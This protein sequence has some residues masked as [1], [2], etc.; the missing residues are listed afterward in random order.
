VVP[1]DVPDVV[2]IVP[3]VGIPS[4][5]AGSSGFELQT[6][7][8]AFDCSLAATDRCAVAEGWGGAWDGGAAERREGVGVVDLGFVAGAVWCALSREGWVGGGEFWRGVLAA[9]IWGKR[10]FRKGGRDEEPVG[11]WKWFLTHDGG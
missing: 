6:G 10:L 4:R 1:V 7:E 11:V 8:R 5:R 2:V 3:V 9:F